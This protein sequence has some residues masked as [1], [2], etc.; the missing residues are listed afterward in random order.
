M[1]G[2]HVTEGGNRAVWWDP[3]QLKLRVFA[4][5]G[6]RQQKL[7]AHSPDANQSIEAHARWKARR[8]QEIAQG[9]QPSL[10]AR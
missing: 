4:K 3:S 8:E 7:L 5:E 10:T 9:S 1:T 2:L 6:V